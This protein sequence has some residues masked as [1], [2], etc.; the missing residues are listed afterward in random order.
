MVPHLPAYVTVPFGCSGRSAV[1]RNG[2]PP[3]SGHLLCITFPVPTK[4]RGEHLAATATQEQRQRL[5]R[6]APTCLYTVPLP[7]AHTNP[8]SACP[9]GMACSISSVMCPLVQHTSDKSVCIVS[10]PRGLEEVALVAARV[11]QLDVRISNIDMSRI[12]IFDR[13][14]PRRV[15]DADQQRRLHRGPPD[16][17]QIPGS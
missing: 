14:T 4:N 11:H 13:E 7:T 3:L 6:D 5:D 16:L 10:I 2:V 15:L 12:S 8:V 1:V 9:N 17:P